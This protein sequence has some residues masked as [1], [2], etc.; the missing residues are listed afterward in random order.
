[1]DARHY[2]YNGAAIDISAAMTVTL[3][4]QPVTISGSVSGYSFKTYVLGDVTLAANNTL[5][6]K[7]VDGVPSIDFFKFVPNA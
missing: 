5:E 4:G 3:N 6:V 1:M 7:N 2:S